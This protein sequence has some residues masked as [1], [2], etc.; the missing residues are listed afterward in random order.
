MSGCPVRDGCSRQ[1][2]LVV[3]CSCDCLFC[4]VL[5]LEAVYT[6]QATL[7]YDTTRAFRYGCYLSVCVCDSTS[8]HFFCLLA[9]FPHDLPFE[10]G[11][12]LTIIGPCNKVFW[13]LA[14]D[15]WGRRGVVPINH[16]L[17]ASTTTVAPPPE[18]RPQ[19]P[20]P[21]A[22][23]PPFPLPPVDRPQFPL[24]PEDR[25][26]FP[27]HPEDRPQFPPHPADRPQFP[28]PPA[29][30]PQF[31]PHPADRPP[32]TPPT[33]HRAPA[34]PPTVHRAPATPPTVHRP[35][36]TPPT[37]H[38]APGTT[39]PSRAPSSD[40]TG[41]DYS[42]GERPFLPPPEQR[43]M[44]GGNTATLPPSS[45]KYPDVLAFRAKSGWCMPS[46]D[47]VCVRCV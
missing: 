2:C 5:H 16:L 11:D 38:R 41:G 15:R 44:S 20:P 47:E 25:P 46:V 26:P 18:D 9:E 45:C 43:R 24:P 4:L 13:Y 12:T 27:P 35:P 36:A 17:L 23:R 31:P 32:A 1:R 7:V 34:T 40:C 3:S 19:P 10:E 6:A 14:E 37:V 39:V 21:L 28:P 8:S 29:D 33:V 22:D 42:Y 30:R